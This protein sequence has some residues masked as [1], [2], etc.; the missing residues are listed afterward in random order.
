[1]TVATLRIPLPANR[2]AGVLEVLRS[3][4]R[5]VQAQAGCLGCLIYEEQSPDSALL[6]V[7]RWD[8]EEALETHI[9]SDA[10]RRI[11]KAIEL[12]GGPPEVRFDKVSASEGIELIQRL[13]RNL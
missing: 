2:R 13:R 5:L 10:Y 6:M 11:L 8:S 1:M 4:Q 9:R 12:G 7:E 3:I